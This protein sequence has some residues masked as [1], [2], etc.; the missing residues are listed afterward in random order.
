[1]RAADREEQLAK[2]RAEYFKNA[3]KALEKVRLRYGE[4]MEGLKRMLQKRTARLPERSGDGPEK[5]H[6]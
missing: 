2:V 4:E 5:G 6:E 1:M 3:A